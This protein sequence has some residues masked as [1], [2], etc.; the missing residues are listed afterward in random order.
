[1]LFHWQLWSGQ[2][3]TRELTYLTMVGAFALLLQA[4]MRVALEPPPVLSTRWHLRI[5][6]V[7]A[8]VAVRLDRMP[9]LPLAIVGVAVIGYSAY[10]SIITIQNHFRLG[11]A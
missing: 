3:S 10:F 2:G 4:L 5:G 1:L 6:V 9:W 7:R 8:R 11:T